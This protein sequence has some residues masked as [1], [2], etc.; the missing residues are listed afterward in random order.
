M[1]V[2]ELVGILVRRERCADTKAVIAASKLDRIEREQHEAANDDEHEANLQE[3]I[4]NQTRAVKVL[5]DKWFVDKGYGFG[6]AAETLNFFIKTTGKDEA[7]M[8]QQRTGQKREELWRNRDHWKA[9]AE[10]EERF[11]KMK[12]EAWRLFERLLGFKRKTRNEFEENSA[13]R[14]ET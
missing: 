5:V 14:S 8:R 11:Q 1:Q 6:K 12:E 2:R 9:R 13:V 10:D 3:V 4:T 7:S